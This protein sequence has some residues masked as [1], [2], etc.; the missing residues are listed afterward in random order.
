MPTFPDRPT[1]IPKTEG[2][3]NTSLEAEGYYYTVSLPGNTKTGQTNQE[4]EPLDTGHNRTPGTEDESTRTKYVIAEIE[5]DEDGVTIS[6]P[7]LELV[8]TSDTENEAVAKF[9]GLDEYFHYLMAHRQQLDERFKK[10]LM[11]VL[12]N[13]AITFHKR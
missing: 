4:G 13:P 9:L 6:C 3:Y 12:E 5:V 11:L 7:E 1:L 2:E 10:H 8:A